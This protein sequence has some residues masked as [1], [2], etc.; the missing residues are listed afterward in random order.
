MERLSPWIKEFNSKVFLFNQVETPFP[1]AYD[2]KATKIEPMLQ[3][4]H[5][6]RD[7]IAESWS[8]N[9]SKNS[10]RNSYF[11]LRQKN[12]LGSDITQMALKK[13]ADLITLTTEGGP[14][15]QTFLGSVA[16]DVIFNAECPVLVFHQ[17]KSINKPQLKLKCE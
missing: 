16:R 3:S 5:R 14:V 11:V 9:L 17:P 2:I 7:K 8:N 10:I 12:Y 6:R 1:E 15:A 13:N 4:L